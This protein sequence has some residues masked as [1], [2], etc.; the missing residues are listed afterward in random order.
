MKEL[1][2]ELLKELVHYNPN[3]GEFH[4]KTRTSEHIPNNHHQSWNAKY[5]GKLMSNSDG[6]GYYDSFILGIHYKLHRL[7]W[8]Y[9]HGD[10]P[11][12]IDHI[13][14]DT[15]DNRLDN[16]R[17]VTMKINMRN[18]KL[19]AKN[20]SGVMGVTWHNI[21]KTWCVRIKTSGVNK[22]LCS[23]K[24]F[25]EACCVRKSAERSLGFH[26]NHGRTS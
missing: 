14:G 20:T 25:F 24:D 11:L 9:T 7:A 23:T 21:N 19:N 4:W 17:N 22:Y 13:N 3:T 15:Y 12:V 5:A 8:F 2:Q 26:V 1:T 16:L 6:R 10:V 18:Q